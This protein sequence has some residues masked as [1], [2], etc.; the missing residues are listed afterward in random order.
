M[1]LTQDISGLKGKLEA[2]K[3]DKQATERLWLAEK[4]DLNSRLHQANALVTQYQG[5]ARKK[6]K[7]YDRLQNQLAKMV[8]DSQRGQ[9]SVIVLTKPLP[10][11]H[12]ESLT[13]I[14]TLKDAELSEARQLKDAL[15]VC[16][17]LLL[18]CTYIDSH[19]YSNFRS[20]ILTYVV[21]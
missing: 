6:D 3:E 18:T 21:W 9:K 12:Q 20:K 15:E 10:K 1:L 4:N 8:K 16:I 19:H 5:T 13:N 17:L 11:K 14:T 7:D 2:I